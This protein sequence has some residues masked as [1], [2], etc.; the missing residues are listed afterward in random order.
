MPLDR[1]TDRSCEPQSKH[2]IAN[3][4]LYYEEEEVDSLATATSIDLCQLIIDVQAESSDT[5]ISESTL[6]STSPIVLSIPL[7]IPTTT[8]AIGHITALQSFNIIN[9][10]KKDNLVSPTGFVQ[11]RIGVVSGI[12]REIYM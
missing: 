9:K 8:D 1:S 7:P 6:V 10:V 2:D 12:A 5:T 11:L 4:F 3:D